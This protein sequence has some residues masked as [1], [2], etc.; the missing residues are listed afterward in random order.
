MDEVIANIRTLANPVQGTAYGSTPQQTFM[1]A[2]A[3]LEKFIDDKAEN[4][5]A[6]F[7]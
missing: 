7:E 5:A 2:Q 1:Q 4:W 6:F 3:N